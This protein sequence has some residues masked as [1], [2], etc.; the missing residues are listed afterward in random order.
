MVVYVYSSVVPRII[1]RI[2][3]LIS[4]N[5]AGAVTVAKDRTARKRHFSNTSATPRSTTNAP[6]VPTTATHGTTCLTI[7]AIRVAGL[8]VGGVTAAQASIGLQTVMSIGNMS[9]PSMF[10]GIAS[11]ISLQKTI[12]IRYGNCLSLEHGTLS[13]VQHRLSHRKP[14]YKCYQCTAK[15]KTYGG[16]V[17]FFVFFKKPTHICRSSISNTARAVTLTISNSTSSLPNA[18]NRATSSTRTAATNYATTAIPT[19]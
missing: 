19:C 16:M 4:S 2:I 8:C 14:T 12:Y 10:A 9:M 15:F 11:S 18:A 1:P 13:V 7:V 3:P 17:S 6:S 5:L